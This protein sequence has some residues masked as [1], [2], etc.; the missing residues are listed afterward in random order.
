MRKYEKSIVEKIRRNRIK[1]EVYNTEIE[2]MPIPDCADPGVID[3]RVLTYAA[4]FL[5]DESDEI[6]KSL[7]ITEEKIDVKKEKISIGERTVQ[8][9]IYTPVNQYQKGER[10]VCIFCHGG[11]WVSGSSKVVENA[12]LLLAERADCIVFNVDYDLAPEYQFPIAIEEV[13]GIV[14]YVHKYAEQYGI[15]PNKIAIGGDSA[16][17]NLAAA[18]ALKDRD[19]QTGLLKLQLLVYPVVTAIS[20][21]IRGFEWKLDDYEIALEQ[22]TILESGLIL[23]RPMENGKEVL[24]Q[25]L[26]QYVKTKDDFLNPY[27]SPMLAE[28]FQGVCPA[29]IATAEFDGLRLQGEYY[30][31]LLRED[32]C[33]SRII[34]YKG[35]GH[36]FLDN[37]GYYPQTEALVE[38]MADAVKN[39]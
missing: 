20:T 16:G 8:V 26:M 5:S 39:M 24:Q 13:Y 30:G 9:Y 1:A 36:A 22:R 35:M 32:N 23:G 33:K 4:Q 21:G 6:P 29:L 11:S 17:G 15:N 2:I 25:A 37:L 7:R 10:S 38:E 18:V 28:S 27:V 19:E 14:K 12:M 34:R 3:S 31:K